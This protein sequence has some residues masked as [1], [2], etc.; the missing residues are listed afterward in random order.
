MRVAICDDE[1]ADAECLHNYIKTHPYQHEVSLFS[2]ASD[3]LDNIDGGGVFDLI[4]LDIQMPGLNGWDAAHMLRERRTEAFVVLTTVAHQYV[5]NSFRLVWNFVVKP[6]EKTK[7]HTILNDAH[8]AKSLKPVLLKT[9]KYQ[10]SVFAKDILY[11]EV[12]RNYLH[13]YMLSGEEHRIRTTLSDFE[14]ALSLSSF[15]RP[16][17]SFLVNLAQVSHFKTAQVILKNKKH[18]SISRHREGS[19]HASYAAFIGGAGHG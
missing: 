3:M 14:Q 2:A 5:F 10:I 18:I 17:Q 6:V 12:K 13:I 7:I 19:F 1:P 15:S 8:I 16:H 11:V 9:A 4:F